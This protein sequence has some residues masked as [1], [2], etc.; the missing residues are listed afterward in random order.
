MEV[1]GWTRWASA[2]GRGEAQYPFGDW[3]FG[4]NLLGGAWTRSYIYDN[5]TRRWVQMTDARPEGIEEP[6]PAEDE[7]TP[8][9]DQTLARPAGARRTSQA[10]PSAA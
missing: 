3:P 9:T 5:R 2:V 1:S 7:T 6:Q 4:G 10:G 8:S